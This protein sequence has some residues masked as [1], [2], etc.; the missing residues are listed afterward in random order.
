MVWHASGIIDNGGFQY[1]FE[2]HFK[3]DP[4]F[5]KTAAAFKSVKAWTCA[6]A[7]EQALELLPKSKPPTSI[8][9][10]LDIYQSHP[11]AKREAIDNLFFR[12]SSEI[13]T[14]L[15]TY[16][17]ENRQHFAKTR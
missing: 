8:D 5:A 12:Q 2:G 6:E 11:W 15:A 13:R 3:G 10:R 17:R 4:Y 7:I 1:L 16:I 9:K 14:L